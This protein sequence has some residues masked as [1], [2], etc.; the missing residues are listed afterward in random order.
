[1]RFILYSYLVSKDCV[2][3]NHRIKEN[4]EISKQIVYIELDDV[5]MF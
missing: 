1:M 5:S 3:F 4:T 2:N